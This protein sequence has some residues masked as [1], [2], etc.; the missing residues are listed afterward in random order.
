MVG[1]FT[2]TLL[3]PFLPSPL[4]TLPSRGTEYGRI[5]SDLLAVVENG[6][7]LGEVEDHTR[8]REIPG[9]ETSDCTV[10]RRETGEINGLGRG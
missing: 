6:D 9:D 7:Q 1:L 2:V 5:R 3:S 8:D 4:P 10:P